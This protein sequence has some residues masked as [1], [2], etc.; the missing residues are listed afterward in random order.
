M[1]LLEGEETDLTPLLQEY[2]TVMAALPQPTGEDVVPTLALLTSLRQEVAD[3][4]V[5]AEQRRDA[6]GHQLVQMEKRK[7]QIGAYTK[8]QGL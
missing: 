5:A 3:L 7:L 4:L 1:A 2:T 8:A 6:L